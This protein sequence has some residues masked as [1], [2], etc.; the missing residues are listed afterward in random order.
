[1]NHPVLLE[2]MK[3]QIMHLCFIYIIYICIRYLEGPK[4]RKVRYLYLI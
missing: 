4:I 2:I 3:V 1:M